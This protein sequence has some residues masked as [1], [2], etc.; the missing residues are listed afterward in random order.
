MGACFTCKL[1]AVAE[2][3]LLDEY[4]PSTHGQRKEKGKQCPGG[5]RRGSDAS[6][7]PL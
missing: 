3:P 4:L 7:L 5:N 6:F 1:H 2:G